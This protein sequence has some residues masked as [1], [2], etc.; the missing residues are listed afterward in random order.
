[1]TAIIVDLKPGRR[2]RLPSSP[3]Q[4]PLPPPTDIA[5]TVSFK[6]PRLTPAV[7]DVVLPQQITQV[8]DNLQPTGLQ[9]D[10]ESFWASNDTS[11]FFSHSDEVERETV[12]NSWEQLVAS[13]TTET[14]RSIRSEEQSADT[15][16]EPKPT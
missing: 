9:T 1:M 7:V 10:R 15:A 14:G 3:S 12:Y 11:P 13:M 16:A 2:H 8:L 5:Q 4:E 6:S